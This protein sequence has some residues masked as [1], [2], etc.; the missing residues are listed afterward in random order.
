VLWHKGLLALLPVL[1]RPPGAS[2]SRMGGGQGGVRA[3]VSGGV[4]VLWH[5]GLLALLPVLG[6]PAD[7]P[8]E[9]AFGVLESVGRCC[10]ASERRAVLQ[11]CCRASE[12]RAVLQRCCRAS[13]HRA[14][15]QRCCRASE[16]RAVLQR[17]CRASERRPYEPLGN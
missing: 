1:G 3:E 7:D 10:R 6:R 8:P 9:G 11:R 17:C 13:E 2:E 4:G 5:K 16:H 15:L 12:R 14:V